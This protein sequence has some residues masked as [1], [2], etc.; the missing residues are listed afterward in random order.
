LIKSYSDALTNGVKADPSISTTAQYGSIFGKGDP[1][2]DFLKNAEDAFGTV[3]STLGALGAIG[4]SKFA[5]VGADAL[6]AGATTW[7]LG[8]LNVGSGSFSAG[9]SAALGPIAVLPF[10]LDYIKNGPKYSSAILG[11]LETV[12]RIRTALSSGIVALVIKDKAKLNYDLVNSNG[13]I[14]DKYSDITSSKQATGIGSIANRASLPVDDIAAILGQL[15][16][17][18]IVQKLNP[19]LQ[20]YATIISDASSQK[21]FSVPEFQGR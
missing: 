2:I 3:S 17:Y 6:G 5:N 21:S 12:S 9:A 11:V 1:G 7:A 14:I 18:R 4:L 15:Y 10:L 13:K 8:L 19:L 20:D 16:R